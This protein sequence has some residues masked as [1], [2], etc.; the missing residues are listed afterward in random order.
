MM[1]WQV[2]GGATSALAIIGALIAWFWRKGLPALRKWSRFA[3]RVMGVP[4]D[5]H[6]G[7]PEIPGIFER[8]DAQDAVLETIRHEVEFNNGSSVKDAVTRVEKALTDHLNAPTTPST[9][10]NVNPGGSPP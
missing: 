3:D 2:I 1:D 7:Q 10:I 4:A 8:M 6:T 5:S 9:T